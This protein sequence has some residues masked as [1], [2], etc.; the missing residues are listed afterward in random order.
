MDLIQEKSNQYIQIVSTHAMLPSFCLVF[1]HLH[2]AGFYIL[3]NKI[4][5]FHTAFYRGLQFKKNLAF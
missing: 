1:K 5:K 2:Y 3:Q 4:V